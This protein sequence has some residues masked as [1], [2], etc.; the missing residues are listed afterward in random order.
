MRVQPTNDFIEFEEEETE[1]SIPDRFEK[2]VSLYAGKFAVKD[3]DHGLS[4]AELNKAANRIA[5]AVLSLLG[6]S[7]ES[8]AMLF[9]NNVAAISAMLGILK[10]GKV[11][12]P[13]D[14]SYPHARL[15]YMIADSQAKLIVTN[16]KNLALGMEL[17]DNQCSVVNVD[18]LDSSLSDEN[19][20]LSISPD[21]LACIFY[22]SGSTG[23]PKGIADSHKKRLANAMREINDLHICAED[24]LTLLS[25]PAFA[26]SVGDYFPALSN[27]AAV[28]PFDINQEGIGN[29]ERWML[30]EEITVYHSSPT[31][32]RYFMD[33][34]SGETEF[35]RLR[36]IRMGAE[37]LYKWDIERYKKHFSKGC[38]LANVWGTTEGEILQP[39]FVDKETEI[40]GVNVPVGYSDKYSEVMFLDEKDQEL[41]PGEVGEIVTRSFYRS[42]G[43]W[44][45]P[46]LTDTKFRDDLAGGKGRLYYTGDLGK[47]LPDGSIVHLGRMDFQVKIRG[48]RV[49]VAEIEN[50]LCE[51]ADVEEAVVMEKEY[52][53]DDKR[54]VAYIVPRENSS[55]SF[56]TLR[57]Y[58]AEIL[59]S[60]M[61]PSSFVT[62]DALPRTATGKIDRPSLPDPGSARPELDNPFVKPSNPIEEALTEIWAE[63]LYIDEVGI[64]DDFFELGGH[65]L[66]A[67]K[68]ISR[69]VK[70]F[71]A[72]LSLQ[73]LF[74]SPTVAD[75]ALAIAQDQTRNVESEEIDQIL[76]KLKLLSDEE[77]QKL[78]ED[79]ESESDRG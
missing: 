75:M 2:Q 51:N 77:T 70:R 1:Q 11:Y 26:A 47:M 35:P 72:N 65:S 34:L 43:Y 59:P 41:A 73:S 57:G 67:T 44:G 30:E 23:N 25:S 37:P 15:A 3:K 4:Y 78:L 33:T 40:N 9:G 24:N 39:Y 61:I 12:V 45:K 38:L 48:H 27:G 74:Q 22:T 36:L 69:V 49:E 6:E 63:V 58:L 13:L 55:L 31:V 8:V 53:I 21:K 42:P 62:L 29:M 17:A 10:S 18:H 7:A 79:V 19:P 68:I 52:R 64:H 71:Q 54:L 56:R 60:Y 76:M 5:M 46:E 20:G 32:F 16:D 14:P 50:A 28:F 66:L